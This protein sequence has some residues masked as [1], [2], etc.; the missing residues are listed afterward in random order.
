VNEYTRRE[1]VRWTFIASLCLVLFIAPAVVLLVMAKGKTIPDPAAKL[2]AR[3]AQDR[4]AQ[5]RMC[6]GAAEQMATEIDVFKTAAKAARLDDPPP[7]EEPA[8]AKKEKKKRGG[9]GQAPKE[10]EP[11]ASLAWPAAQPAHKLAKALNGCQTPIEATAG[12]RAAAT[13]AWQAIA[14]TAAI[15]PPKEG[16]TAAQLEAA[17][18]ILKLLGGAPIDKVIKAAKDAEIEVRGAAD[19]AQTHADNATVIEPIPEGIL[20]RRAALGVGIAITVIALMISYLS[21]RAASIRRMALLVPLREASRSSQPGVHAAAILSLAA[22]HN[23][24]EPG[25]V[26]GG[27]IGGLAAAAAIPADTDIFIF[28]VMGGL[29][30]GLGFQWLFRIALG[31]R[32]WRKRVTELAEIEKPTIP[33]VLILSGVKQGLEAEFLSFFNGLSP[34]DASTTVEKFAA[35]AEEQILAAADA[36]RLPQAQAGAAPR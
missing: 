24:G 15:E 6:V 33:T 22:K 2:A 1:E 14:K 25:L 12:V 17:R 27:A 13:P 32:R 16:D 5:A 3:A 29:V 36:H 28:G 34:H 26:I 8:N 7:A 30:I 4:A 35:Q 18:A 23:G 10:K 31:A 20:P 19:K 11:D 21:V 9:R